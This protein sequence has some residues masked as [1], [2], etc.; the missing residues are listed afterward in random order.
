MRHTRICLAL[1]IGSAGCNSADEAIDLTTADVEATYA[2]MDTADEDPDFGDPALANPEIA[3]EDPPEVDPT[4]DERPDLRD[5]AHH[6]RVLV[7]WGRFRLQPEATDWTTWDGTLTAN[8]AAVRVLRT[9]RFER[10]MD[11]LVPRSD[12]HTIG[13]VSQ[14]AP[15]FDGVL[16]DVVLHPALNPNNEEVSLTFTSGPITYTLPIAR[17]MRR[18][19]VVDVDDAGNKLAFQV[20]MPDR[21]G[22][23]EGYMAG[24]WRSVEDGPRG[25]LGVILGRFVDETGRIRGK[26][27]GVYGKRPD[28]SQVFFAK[29]IGQDGA[30][31]GLVGGRYREGEF[32]GRLNGR[33][34]R[35]DGVVHGRYF[36][37]DRDH[38]G[39]FLGRW[40]QLCREEPAEGEITPTD[41]ALPTIET[42]VA[43]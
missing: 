24:I 39:T 5:G 13:W 2:G 41:A 35:I 7:A 31:I 4:L 32:A 33:G 25:V 22:C 37:G 42:D 1:L 23:R 21:D 14:T 18:H 3:S 34:D 12:L 20:F 40:S 28:G 36:D 30:F 43:L 8:N 26:I 15:S 29:V 16:V 9:V 27:R 10:P 17:D 19:V 11:H 6:L 38:D